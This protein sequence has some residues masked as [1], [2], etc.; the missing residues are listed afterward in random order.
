MQSALG[1]GSPFNIYALRH[2]LEDLSD[3]NMYTMRVDESD[4]PFW[5]AD[6]LHYL[7]PCM[8][9]NKAWKDEVY[10][11]RKIARRGIKIIDDLH[12]IGD[13]IRDRG[14]TEAMKI[15]QMDPR[16]DID[17]LKKSTELFSMTSVGRGV[18]KGC[19]FQYI[20]W[21]LEMFPKT[22]FNWATVLSVKGMEVFKWAVSKNVVKV[23]HSSPYRTFFQLVIN[24]RVDILGEEPVSLGWGRG[25]APREYC[26]FIDCAL[27]YGFEVMAEKILDL[28]MSQGIRRRSPG[29]LADSFRSRPHNTLIDPETWLREKHKVYLESLRV[30][31]KATDKACESFCKNKKQKKL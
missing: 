10:R 19:S 31:K 8:F 1:S 9:V 24:N 21:W 20:Q 7:V 2:V 14:K 16:W 3:L 5:G 12:I 29:A 13:L 4:I 30:K 25:L 15:L 11:I 6:G 26:F 28:Y 22:R 27:G 18:C 23:K 17:N